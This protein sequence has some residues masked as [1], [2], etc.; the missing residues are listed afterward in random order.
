MANNQAVGGGRP[1]AGT[2]VANYFEGVVH[3]SGSTLTRMRPEGDG[4]DGLGGGLYNG[5]AS[6]HPSNLNAPTVLTVEGMSSPTTGP[7]EAPAGPA[8]APARWR[9]LERRHRRHPRHGDQLQ[10]RS[11]AAT[12]PTGA[13]AATVSGAARTA[14]PGSL[15]LEGCASPRTTPT[16][17]TRVR[18]GA[19]ARGSGVG[20]TTWGCSTS[21]R[22]TRIF[23]N[24]AS[25]SHDDVFSL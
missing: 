4:A 25:T 15:Q 11:S 21:T 23:E 9:P 2:E 18:A 24:H 13:A 17:A 22:L 1:A 8:P 16:A 12:G 19:R 10:P 6:T 20:S 7:R 14:R 5:V 3:V